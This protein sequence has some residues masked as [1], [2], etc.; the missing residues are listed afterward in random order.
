MTGLLTF[1]SL[2][3]HTIDNDLRLG[4]NSPLCRFHLSMQELLGYI[5]TMMPPILT[6]AFQY[7]SHN[8]PRWY[9]SSISNMT[10]NVLIKTKEAPIFYSKFTEDLQDIEGSTYASC[11]PCYSNIWSN[12]PNF[13]FC[14]LKYISDHY[15]RDNLELHLGL[16][17]SGSFEVLYPQ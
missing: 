5:L 11:M 13:R 15:I 16:N 4:Y 6:Q 9:C 14:L 10:A 3:M 2:A 1:H 17:A 7:Y 12:V 8:Q